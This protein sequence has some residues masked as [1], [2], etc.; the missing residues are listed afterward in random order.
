MSDLKK[1]LSKEYD[2]EQKYI[3]IFNILE[4]KLAIST[5]ALVVLCILLLFIFHYFNRWY[6]FMP[7][8][9]YMFL[10]IFFPFPLII[11]NQR[12]LKSR[13]NMGMYLE[14]GSKYF[15]F[16][17]IGQIINI[18]MI[19]Q[20]Y[21]NLFVVV[22]LITCVIASFSYHKYVTSN[23]D[24]IMDM[25]DFIQDL[26][27]KEKMV[28]KACIQQ[29]N[30][31]KEEALIQ[32]KDLEVSKQ[33]LKEIAE[34]DLID[35][36]ESL[37]EETVEE[38]IERYFDVSRPLN[39]AKVI[40]PEVFKTIQQHANYQSAKMAYYTLIIFNVF[41]FFLTYTMSDHYIYYEDQKTMIM[42][43]YAGIFLF[44]ILMFNKIYYRK[45]N[46]MSLLLYF[47]ILFYDYKFILSIRLAQDLNLMIVCFMLSVFFN[48][49]IIIILIIAFF[50]KDQ[51]QDTIHL[52]QEY[53]TKLNDQKYLKNIKSQY[54]E[55]KIRVNG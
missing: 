43:I 44:T 5:V 10:L 36:E 14:Y 39:Y 23:E 49:I 53:K 41:G 26:Q 11:N 28:A 6:R 45:F 32:E 20:V 38:E 1:Y 51:F 7:G 54:E 37:I 42:I 13:E 15:I 4:H 50:I 48:I 21:A 22:L 46:V 30:D 25:F 52:K 17:I 29:E 24:Q 16:Y 47:I 40:Y 27:A 8:S 2:P 34:I 33:E 18:I 35:D 19:L 31:L 3:E 9:N 12:S 55:A